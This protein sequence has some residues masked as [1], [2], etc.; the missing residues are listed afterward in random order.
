[1]ECVVRAAWSEPLHGA[2]ASVQAK[3][4]PRANMA[5]ASVCGQEA[6]VYIDHTRIL[7]TISLQ[8]AKKNCKGKGNQ[9][10]HQKGKRTGGRRERTAKHAYLAVLLCVLFS[11]G[12]SAPHC[13]AACYTYTVPHGAATALAADNVAAPAQTPH[14]TQRNSLLPGVADQR[15]LAIRFW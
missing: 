8:W 7:D 6:Y 3:C 2:C 10:T 11:L 13:R 12:R 15:Q 1:M 5:M 9:T 4:A 14:D